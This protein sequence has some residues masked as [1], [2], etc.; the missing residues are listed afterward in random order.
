[1]SFLPEIN[2]GQIQEDRTPRVFTPKVRARP[3]A[4]E[5]DGLRP[6]PKKYTV[7]GKPTMAN[8]HECVPNDDSECVTCGRIMLV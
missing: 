1:M 5:A 4:F 8:L 7:L 3:P 2:D 6:D